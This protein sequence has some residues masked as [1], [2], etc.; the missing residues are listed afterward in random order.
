MSPP[1][2]RD[3]PR[4]PL[5]AARPSRSTMPAVD[6][7]IVR[8]TIAAIGMSHIAVLLPLEKTG[9][10]ALASS[11]QAPSIVPSVAMADSS[12]QDR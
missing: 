3:P 6:V 5:P 2:S 10:V 8:S 4:D 11:A 9:A 7:V 1:P 12:I